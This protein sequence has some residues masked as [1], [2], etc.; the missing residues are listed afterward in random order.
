VVDLGSIALTIMRIPDEE[1]DPSSD[2]DIAIQRLLRSI[3]FAVPFKDRVG[4][5]DRVRDSDRRFNQEGH[6]QV[7]ITIQRE[8]LF[9]TAFAALKDIKGADLKRKLYVTFVNEAGMAES[10]VDAGGLFKELWTELCRVCFHPEYGL[11]AQTGT[12]AGMGE[13]SAGGD[14]YPNPSSA[15][16][17]GLKDEESFYFLGKITGKALYE[18]ITV[19]PRWARF[20]LAQVLGRS[21]N[22]HDLP[23]LDPELY[24]SLMF[25]RTCPA[26]DVPDLCLCFTTTPDLGG[27]GSGSGAEIELIPGGADIAVTAANRLQYIH[28]V[29]HNRLRTSIA[30]QTE[31]FT[32]GL[33]EVLPSAWLGTFSP[34]ELQVL[35]S[36]SQGGIDV[37]DLRTHTAYSGGYGASDRV[38]RDFWAVVETL[39]QRDRA[40]L[41]RFCTSCERAPPLGFAQL[42]PRLTIARVAIRSDADALPTSSTCFHILKLPSYSKREVLREKLLMAIHSGAG[43]EL[44]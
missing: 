33:Y 32:R 2:K 4:L 10:G 37:N 24:K 22:L 16:L 40:A 20:W 21:P 34:P 7:K 17:T 29:A 11:W 30:K 23:S 31:A 27:S 8:R 13:G 36:G 39:S 25:L 41:L 3:P 28:L 12:G 38:I 15:L 18:G 26:S 5:Y 9:E 1:A 42:T 19:G 44:T 43:F 6:S 35:A 14:L